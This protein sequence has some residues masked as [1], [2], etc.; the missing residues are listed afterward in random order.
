MQCNRLKLQERYKNAYDV[1]DSC[2]ISRQ[3]DARSG[4]GNVNLGLTVYTG[5]RRTSL[6]NVPLKGGYLVM[7]RIGLYLAGIMVGMLVVALGSAMLG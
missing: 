5:W 4:L 1:H 7:L 3:R 6:E 2:Y